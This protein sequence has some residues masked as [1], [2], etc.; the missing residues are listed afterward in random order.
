LSGA[1][2]ILPPGP[3][4]GRL[5]GTVALHRD[6]LRFLR[7]AQREFGDVFTIRLATAGPVVVVADPRE[8]GLLAELDPG[9]EGAAAHA[10]RARQGVLPMA[11]GLSVF[12]GDEEEHRGARARVWPAFSPEA[13]GERAAQIAEIVERHVACWPRGRPTRLLPRMRRLADEVFVR[14]VLGVHEQP[15][16]GELVR[17]IGG[18]LWTPG[19]PPL[20]IPAPEDGLLGRAVDAVYRRRRRP[21]A[22]L[23]ESELAERRRRDS[24]GPG[25]L[26]LLLEDEPGRADGALVEELL[27]LLMAG[28]EPI[29]AALTWLALLLGAEP[30][31][32]ER[33][34]REPAGGAYERAVVDESLRLHPPAVAMLRR[35]TRAATLAGHELAAGTSTMAPMPL[36]HRDA[37]SFE[38]PDRFLPERH[39]AAGEGDTSVVG[40]R[41]WPFGHGARSCIAEALARAQLGLTLHALLESV[42]IEPLGARPERMVLRATILVPQRSG[43]VRLH[44]AE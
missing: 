3:G 12:G 13:V 43:L 33:L 23:I 11:S 40:G 19:N 8:A 20:T 4:T 32:A 2:A 38:Q 30:Q 14:E 9:A 17:A 37:R 16:A 7:R 28:Q 41:M 34:R 5:S 39:L 44:A 15:R 10:G 29:A 6:P 1:S 35:L 24:A 18:L 22:A 25:V 42:T 36:L 31:A 27:A 26:G 21:I